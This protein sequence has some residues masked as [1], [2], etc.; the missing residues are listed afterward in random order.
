MK[1][2]IMRHGEAS[3]LSINDADR[4]LT[5]LGQQQTRMVAAWLYSRITLIDHVIVSPYK[6]AQ[7]TLVAVQQNIKTL[8]RTE[9]SSMITPSANP[10]LITRYLYELCQ[11][12]IRSVLLISHLPLVGYLVNEL[13]PDIKPLMFP[14]SSIAC[15]DIDPLTYHGTF[16]W[17]HEKF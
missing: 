13:C 11:K 10:T 2:L 8:G 1:V 9:T 5:P 6:R 3:A 15:I 14:T 12:G 7:Q 17:M 16:E 4:S